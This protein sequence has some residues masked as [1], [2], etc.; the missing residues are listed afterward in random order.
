[1]TYVLPKLYADVNKYKP[2]EYFDYEN[3]ENKWGYFILFYFLYKNNFKF[4]IKR[5]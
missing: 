3:Y 4:F 1:M 2:T 5:S